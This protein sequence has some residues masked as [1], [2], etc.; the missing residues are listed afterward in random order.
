MNH[1]RYSR[2]ISV[3]V[4]AA[5]LMLLVAAQP[6]LAASLEVYRSR[7]DS[8]WKKAADVESAFTGGEVDHT[9]SREL[10]E[11]I[12]REFPGSERIEWFGGSVEVSNE[13]LLAR[14]GEFEKASDLKQRLPVISSIR[15]HLSALSYKLA[16][17]DNRI[18]ETRSKDEDKQK[19]GEILRRQEYQKPEK[20]EESAFQRW[21][22][23]ML[24]WFMDLWPKSSSQRQPL[25]GMEG[26]AVVL[27]V[28]LYIGLIALVGLLIF[29]VLPLL[30]P[31]LRREPKPKKKK[32]RVILGEQI[33]ED[34][35]ASDLFG[36]AE[37]LARE[38]DL[39]AA[40]RK[41]YIALLCDLS[42]RRI[43]GLARNKT[44]RDYLRDVRSRRDLHVRMQSATDM[45]ERHWYGFQESQPNDWVR[46]TEEYREA[47]RSS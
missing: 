6:V 39:R 5:V 33:G 3:A 1:R 4:F 25:T 11:Q 20:A 15:E 12:R 18:Q 38:G 42:D 10:V 46:F 2:H 47:I 34:Q 7:V 41:G 8:A 29:K 43:I 23:G 31:R 45:F 9:A 27:R 16:E 35:A 24:E 37:R 21:L 40:I 26:F 14:V 44:N 17:L 22:R 30:V 28:L 19:L 13:W 36:E 32:S